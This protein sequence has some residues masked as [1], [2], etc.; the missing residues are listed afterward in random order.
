MKL[1]KELEKKENR[2]MK[3]LK[4]KEHKGETKKGKE[5]QS[6][7]KEKHKVTFAT[8]G[9]NSQF[10]TG[11]TLSESD[12]DTI[13]PK[14][15]LAYSADHDSSNLWICCDKCDVWFHLKCTIVKSKWTIPDTYFCE[16]CQNKRCQITSEKRI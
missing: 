8:V 6:E 14:C 13:C 1:A 5:N 4:K 9:S 3:A 2:R 15:G 7:P 12:D 16:E 10:D 11:E